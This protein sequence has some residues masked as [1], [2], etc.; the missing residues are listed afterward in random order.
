MFFISML[1]MVLNSFLLLNSFSG[2]KS[3]LYNKKM[4]YETSYRDR[5]NGQLE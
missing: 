5:E 1:Q 4:K 2:I 3:S